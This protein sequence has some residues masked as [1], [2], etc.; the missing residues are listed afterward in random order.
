MRVADRVLAEKVKVPDLALQHPDLEEPGQSRKAIKAA[1]EFL[2]L[3]VPVIE[4][5]IVAEQ[6]FS[7]P[8]MK[9]EDFPCV[10][11]PWLAFW[12]EYARPRNAPPGCPDRWG[13]LV[14]Q[15]NVERFAQQ[16]QKR[17]WPVDAEFSYSMCL[18]AELR[19]QIFGPCAQWDIAI[20]T[21]GLCQRADFTIM[22]SHLADEKDMT[23]RLMYAGLQSICFLQCKNVH[24]VDGEPPPPKV[25]RAQARKLGRPPLTYSVVKI[26][27]FGTRKVRRDHGVSVHAAAPRR[28]HTVPGHFSHFGDC[29]P[30][31]HEPKGLAFGKLTG[32]FWT[33]QHVRGDLEAGVVAH[34]YQIKPKQ[35]A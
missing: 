14:V 8:M 30:G 16:A 11:P 3:R 5:T 26:D 22:T 19:S 10:R 32:M 24:V 33:P 31:V 7:A 17:E 1:A 6:V 23:A 35:R 2:R 28:L 20:D 27:P 15:H 9:I 12:L 25:A 4:A 21:R 29:C 34:D 13:L 18:F